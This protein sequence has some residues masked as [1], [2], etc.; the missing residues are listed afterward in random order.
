MMSVD[1]LTTVISNLLQGTG[2]V[3]FI[4]YVIRGLKREITTLNKTVETQQKTLLAMERQV[5]ETE[6]LGEVYRKFLHN[7]PADFEKF[8]SVLRSAKDETIAELERS[9]RIKDERL[10]LMQGRQYAEVS[11][12]KSGAS[13]PHNLA[14]LTSEQH[15]NI[16]QEV[17][18]GEGN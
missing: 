1:Q 13:A 15:A 17:R 12:K 9:N 18:D 6:R 11:V 5:L 7:I 2:V 14:A 16:E 4:T 10:R 3:V 8:Q